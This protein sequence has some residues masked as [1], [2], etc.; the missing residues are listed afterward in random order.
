MWKPKVPAGWTPYRDGQWIWYDE[1]GF[2]WVPGEPW[3][4]LPFHYGRWIE[5]SGVGWVWAPAKTEVFK[6]GEAYWLRETNLVGWGPLAPGETWDARAVPKLYARA[7]TTIGKW[8]ENVR[9]LVP[10]DA[11]RETQ[12]HRSRVRGGAAITG[13]GCRAAGRGAAGVASRQHAHRSHS[14]RCNFRGQRGP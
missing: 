4:W 6:P 14:A 7:N 9:E 1:L 3:G 5:E 10:A 13:D 2:T 8:K 11:I 12:D